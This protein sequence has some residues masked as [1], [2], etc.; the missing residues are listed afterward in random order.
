[1][2]KRISKRAQEFAALKARILDEA[3]AGGVGLGVDGVVIG[4]RTIAARRAIA[5][6]LVE[7]KIRVW[8]GFSLE[9]T[10]NAVLHQSKDPPP[11]RLRM[12]ATSKDRAV[13]LVARIRSNVDRLY[14][15]TLSFEAFSAAQR[16][17]AAVIA[18][19]NL[20]EYTGA[21]LRGEEI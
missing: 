9:E 10:R 15:G 20:G 8:S 12:A 7:G 11:S 21:L 17:I 19:E 13:A 14:S 16:A 1:M 4:L 18:A 3:T 6:L 2:T 5:E